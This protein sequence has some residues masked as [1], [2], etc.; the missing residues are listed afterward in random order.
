MPFF[1]SLKAKYQVQLRSRHFVFSHFLTSLLYFLF[2]FSPTVFFKFP[3]LF[4]FE[5][6]RLY[7]AIYLFCF[8]IFFNGSL[9]F[10][11]PVFS[12]RLAFFLYT[13]CKIYFLIL[14]SKSNHG[15]KKEILGHVDILYLNISFVF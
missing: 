13:S 10:F 12:F 5:C 11:F 4:A 14:F 9:S 7:I 1:H 15:P 3:M 2:L 6:Y 8:A